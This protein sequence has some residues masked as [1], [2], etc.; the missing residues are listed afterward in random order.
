MT[1]E[2]S[3]AAEE[4]GRR[5]SRARADLLAGMSHDLRTPLNA[6]LGFSDLMRREPADGAGEVRV[7]VDWVEHIHREA[8]RLASLAED[9]RDL[10][11]LE[12]GGLESELE[13]TAVEVLPVATEAVAAVRAFAGG[14]GHEVALEV[15][16]GEAVVADRGR[17]LQALRTLLADTIES[18]ADGGRIRIAID[19]RGDEFALAVVSTS[20]RMASEGLALALTRGLVEALHG[21]LEVESTGEGRVSTITLPA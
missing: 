20:S 9:I 6:I 3:A 11:R 18:T 4:I 21:R 2:Q 17:L 5:A 19:R 13:L 10:S 1:A 8:L 15:P 7:P 12:G 14:K 16:A